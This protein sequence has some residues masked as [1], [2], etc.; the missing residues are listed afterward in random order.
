MIFKNKITEEKICIYHFI[1]LIPLILYSFYKNA[2]LVYLKTQDIMDLFYPI[3]LLGIPL[4]IILLFKKIKKISLQMNDF[5]MFASLLFLPFNSNLLIVYIIFLLFYILSNTKLKL[6]YPI[7]LVLTYFFAFNALETFTLYNKIE[8]LSSYNYK[9]LDY[10]IG[11]GDSLI[12]TSSLFAII[13]SY[14]F[15][16]SRKYFKKNIVTIF[17]I[18]YLFIGFILSIIYKFDYSYISLIIAAVIF[19]GS[20]FR[21]TFNEFKGTILFST[22]LAILTIIFNFIFNYYT[23]VFIAILIAQITYLCLPIKI[24]KLYFH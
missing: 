12:F 19:L 21:F 18:T 9:L 22:I 15:L 16:A 14:I 13:L 24:K 4:F 8:N 17:T 10:F 2:F 23:G 11:K 1:S 7:L 3:L 6:P 20:N 5:Y